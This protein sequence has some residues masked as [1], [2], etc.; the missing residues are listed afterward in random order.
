[1]R[2]GGDVAA[3]VSV[4]DTEHMNRALAQPKVGCADRGYAGKTY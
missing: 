3:D 1:M 4:F 2:M